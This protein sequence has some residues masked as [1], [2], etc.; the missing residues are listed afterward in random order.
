MLRPRSPLWAKLSLLAGVL[1]VLGS[2]GAL[3]GTRLVAARY[4]GAVQ[5]ADL[6]GDAATPTPE[7]PELAGPLDLLLVGIDPR[8]SIAD[9]IPRADSVILVHVPE[10]LDRAYLISLPRDLLVTIPPFRRAGYWG[11]QDKLAHAMYFGAQVPGRT[12]PD[13]AAGFT[14]L[15]RTVSR[16]TG[17]KDFD[18]GAIVTFTGFKRIV[19]ALGGVTMYLDQDV[20]SIHLKPDGNHR[21][22]SGTGGEGPYAYVGP[23]KQYAKGTRHLKGWEALDY[24]RQRYIDGGDY[25]RQRHQQQFLRAMI[26]RARAR[27]VVTNPLKLDRVLTAAGAALTFNGRGHSLLEYALTLRHLRSES[28]TLVRLPGGGVSSG[29]QYLGERLDPVAAGFF[30]ALRAERVDDYLA[31][32]PQLAT[33]LQ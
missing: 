30:A 9:W 25:A 2:G 18:A 15:A 27:D 17:I 26:N 29:G 20:T 6:F 23:Q 21:E 33:P 19:D 31:R 32:H 28:I 13:V 5:T 22:P 4:E 12:Q 11:G 16:Y 10:G 8:D 14:L 24:V 1:L 7:P 3:A